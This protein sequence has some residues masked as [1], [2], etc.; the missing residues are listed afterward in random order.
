M[1]DIVN[2]IGKEVEVIANGTSYRGTLVEVSD[3]EVHIKSRLQYVSLPAS[4]VT[5]VRL[6]EGNNRQWTDTFEV[7]QEEKTQTFEVPKEEKKDL[8]P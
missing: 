1:P 2:M 5:E 3:T 8:I 7:P 6:D 4:S